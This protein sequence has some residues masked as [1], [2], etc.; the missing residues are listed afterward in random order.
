MLSE[1]KNCKYK[2]SC[3]SDEYQQ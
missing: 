1:A 3:E 2:V